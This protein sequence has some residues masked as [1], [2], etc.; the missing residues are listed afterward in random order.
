[1]QGERL[2]FSGS[3]IFFSSFYETVRRSAPPASGLW[4]I[5]RRVWVFIF[6]RFV[7]TIAQASDRIN[8]FLQLFLQKLRTRLFVR[9]TPAQSE[10][11][12]S[13]P[14][15]RYFRTD[16]PRQFSAKTP[17]F[18]SNCRPP[19]MDECTAQRAFRRYALHFQPFLFRC[20]CNRVCPILHFAAFQKPSF[21]FFPV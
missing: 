2:P 15:I 11:F 16:F 3:R 5:C 20:V 19:I 12:W 13:L 7:L 18:P 21:M 8:S 4:V 14:T 9:T 6:K 17:H 10:I 1:M